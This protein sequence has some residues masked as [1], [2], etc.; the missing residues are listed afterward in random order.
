[1]IQRTQEEITA[2][3]PADA[4][5]LLS[6]RCTTF[7][8]EKYIAQCLESFL[9]QDT[10][11]PFEICV[12][13]DASPDGTAD[14]VRQYAEKYPKVIKPLFEVENQY[15]KN[16]G[17]FTRIVTS[18]LTGKYVAMC[19]GDD[20]WTDPLK[21]QRQV[22]YLEAHPDCAMVVHGC[23]TI[24]DKTGENE[25][26]FPVFNEERDIPTEEVILGGGGLFGTNTMVYRRELLEHT[27]D[28]YWDASPVGDFPLILTAASQGKVHY[29][30]N[31]MSVYRIFSSGSWS[32]TTL[33][34][35][36]AFE[37]RTNHVKGCRESLVYYDEFT[38]HKYSKAIDQKI[39]LN[40]FNLY[41]DFGK[42]SLLKTTEHYKQR[43]LVG[44]LK[45]FYHC[46]RTNRKQ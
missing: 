18:M 41:W 33:A 25:G 9:I 7:K 32:S 42:W 30:P 39:D 4:K 16:D 35:K 21:L 27:R 3:W 36:N 5:P 2:K 45:A 15:S 1:M 8:Q 29:M 6:I 10:N 17:S 40:D 22:D 43:S 24:N 12:H 13:E 31:V 26:R 11:F 19:E 44:K 28:K 46:L 23:V 37:K 20:Y 14:I 38:N 34:S